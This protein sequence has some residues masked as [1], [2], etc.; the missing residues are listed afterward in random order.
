MTIVLEFHSPHRT[1]AEVRLRGRRASSCPARS[2][3]LPLGA[4]GRSGRQVRTRPTFWPFFYFFFFLPINKRLPLTPRRVRTIR[5]CASPRLRRPAF[6]HVRPATIFVFT[7]VR[8]TRDSAVRRQQVA[9]YRFPSAESASLS[10]GWAGC[11]R[12]R[13][14]R[15]SENHVFHSVSYSGKPYAR[16]RIPKIGTANLYRRKVCFADPSTLRPGAA[17]SVT[18]LPRGNFAKYAPDG[19]AIGFRKDFRRCSH[20]AARVIYRATV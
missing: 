12:L 17:V 14:V 11:C 18:P 9:A 16:R 1:I 13:R 7:A 6:Q 20:D 15:R 5:V 4:R 10:C 19:R 3:P 2:R 8:E